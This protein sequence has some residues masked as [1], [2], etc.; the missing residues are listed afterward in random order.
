MFLAVEAELG[1]RR[2]QRTDLASELR[3]D[4]DEVTG[5]SD[6]IAAEKAGFESRRS[7]RDAR[8][9]VQQG[10]A[11]KILHTQRARCYRPGGRGGTQ[12]AG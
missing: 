1:N 4:G 2:G 9:V 8:T 5:R 10:A 7:Y 6:D 3:H 12:G 11:L